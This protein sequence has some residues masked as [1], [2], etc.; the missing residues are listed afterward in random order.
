LAQPRSS[1]RSGLISCFPDWGRRSVLDSDSYL[2]P[3]FTV[4]LSCAFKVC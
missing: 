2:F 4:S 3:S 1:W